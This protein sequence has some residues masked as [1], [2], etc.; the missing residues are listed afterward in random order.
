MDFTL[1]TWMQ[2]LNE[3]GDVRWDADLM[4]LALHARNTLPDP[5]ARLLESRRLTASTRPLNLVLASD[6]DMVFMGHA[7]RPRF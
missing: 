5:V 3:A 1:Q 7:N 6:R 4:N 2:V